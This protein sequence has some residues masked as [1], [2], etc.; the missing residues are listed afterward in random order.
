MY[1]KQYHHIIGTWQL[2]SASD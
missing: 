1:F 2:A